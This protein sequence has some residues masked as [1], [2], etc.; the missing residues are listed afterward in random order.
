M[1]YPDPPTFVGETSSDPQGRP[2]IGDQEGARLYWRYNAP[3][4]GGGGG[5]TLTVADIAERDALTG[6]DLVKI[7]DVTSTGGV[8]YRKENTDGSG[9]WIVH[10]SQLTMEQAN[11]S[12]IT[13]PELDSVITITDADV[14]G[15]RELSWNGSSWFILAKETE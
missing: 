3:G 11:W 6:D 15:G 1:A 2:Y 5:G 7:V 8:Q 14:G 9:N 10:D 4:V 13:E 12:A